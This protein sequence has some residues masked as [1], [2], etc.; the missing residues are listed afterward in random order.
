MCGHASGEMEDYVLAALNKGLQRIVFLE[1]MEEGIVIP[2]SSWLT[3]DDFDYYFSEGK[4]LQHK[5]SGKIEIGLGVECGYN[6]ACKEKLLERLERRSWDQIGISCHFLKIAGEENH[7]NLL[8]SKPESVARANQY[9][10]SELFS[11][12]LDILLEAV[13]ELNGTVLCHLDAAFRWVSDHVLTDE[14]YHKIDELLAAAASKQMA[15]EINT[16]GVTIREE[17]FPNSRIIALAQKHGM[18]IL[19]GSD[20]HKPADVGNYFDQF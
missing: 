17:P 6:P 8:S 18:P 19:L 11:R 7:L 15:L 20:A 14:H 5:F 16:S 10:S 4:R 13:T 12:Y 2:Q 3:E 9:Y 1:H